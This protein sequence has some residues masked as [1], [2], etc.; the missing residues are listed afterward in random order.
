MAKAKR[1]GRRRP[2][3]EEPEAHDE[4]HDDPRLPKTDDWPKSM[5][6]PDR[7]RAL[8]PDDGWRKVKTP[9]PW[10]PYEGAKLEGV[11]LGPRKAQGQYGDYDKH[12]IVE[13]RTNKTVYVTG[14]VADSLF[15]AGRVNEGQR[16]RLIYL[17]MKATQIGEYKDYEL[18]VKD[19]V[20]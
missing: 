15:T 10:R 3:S 1:P 19:P 7:E 20:A 5:P 4:A 16:I 6:A 13:D 11:Y 12:L 18:Y 2:K 17:G 14:T 9:R 8:R